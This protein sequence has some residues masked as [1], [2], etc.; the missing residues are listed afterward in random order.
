MLRGVILG[1]LAATGA[2]AAIYKCPAP[3]GAVAYSDKPC[4]GSAAADNQVEAKATEIGGSFG[5]SKEQ[6][7][8]WS[9]QPGP[10]GRSGGASRRNY[11]GSFSSTYL[12]SV[13]ISNGIEQGMS[14]GDVRRSWGAPSAVNPGEP[15][16][17]VYYWPNGSA[18]VYLVGGCV[19]RVD[20]AYG[21]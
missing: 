5:V 1:V 9:R 17:W 21:G 18:Y 10:A 13:I 11:C 3:G 14:A 6:Q 2:E 15:E 12:R 4:E 7:E 16:Q 19:W 20:G 8:V